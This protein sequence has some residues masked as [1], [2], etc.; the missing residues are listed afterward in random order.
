MKRV[1]SILFA[2]SLVLSFSL[3]TATPVAAATTYYVATTGNNVNGGTS[4]ADA[5]LTIQHAVSTVASGDT[6]MVAAGTY[7]ETGQIVI[8]KNLTIVG[9][10]AGSSI[11]KKAEDTG[12]PSSGNNRGWVLVNAGYTLNMSGLTLDGDVKQISI[13]ILSF[14]TTTV[15]GCEIKD[16]SWS[17]GSYYGRGV[18]LYSGTA[19]VVR[20]TVFSNIRRIGVFVFGSG[21]S[22]LTEGNTY[23]GKGAIDCLDYGIE[24]GGGA[25]AT[26][27][28]NTVTNC[29]G[30]ASSDGSTSAGILVTDYWGPGTQ[31]IITGNTLTGN[32]AGIAVGYLGTDASVVAANFNN[33]YGNTSSG[34]D[35]VGAVV[36]DGENNWWGDASGPSGQGPGTGDAVSTNVDYDPWLGAKMT[37]QPAGC[38][39][40]RATGATACPNTDNVSGAATGGSTDTTVYVAEYVDNP[41]GA[42][43][44]FHGSGCFFDVHVSGTLPTQLVI[45]ANCPG[46]AL[47]WFDGTVWQDVEPV[48]Y[49][50]GTVRATLNNSTSTPLISDLT[51]TPFGL[52]TLSVVGWE[53]H[54]INKLGVLLPWIALLAAIVAGASL[55]VL[56]RRRAQT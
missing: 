54:P 41:S 23:T 20:N 11:V 33:I 18:C 17:T 45:E 44:G 5:W 10:G 43:P 46:S 34:I 4:W 25:T 9:A 19:N 48:E 24:L 6:I 56:R 21:V 49:I 26:I 2:L 47:R 36:V 42:G 29:L 52:G 16:I 30:V 50:N 7:V 8:N 3:V 35:Q 12:D 39:A 13:A 40:D 53:T 27:T 1:F 22:A 55:L 32:T 14:G 28:G 38:T 15:F 51:G 37:D 31:A